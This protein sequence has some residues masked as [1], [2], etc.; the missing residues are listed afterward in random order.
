MFDINYYN[1]KFK[2]NLGSIGGSTPSEG[3]SNWELWGSAKGTN[4]ITLPTEYS[5]VMFIVR[6][7]SGSDMTTR[8]IHYSLEELT[9]MKDDTLKQKPTN[10]ERNIYTEDITSGLSD[11]NYILTYYFNDN[12][13]AIKTHKGQTPS[14]IY[15]LSVYYKKKSPI[16]VNVGTESNWALWGETTGT[17]AI[18]LPSDYSEIYITMTDT[19]YHTTHFSGTYIKSDIE[20][21]LELSGATETYLFTTNGAT[22]GYT[23]VAYTGTSIKPH[24]YNSVTPSSNIKTTVYYKKKCDNVLDINDMGEWKLQGSATGTNKITLPNEYKEILLFTVN[25]QIQYNTH[26]FK[27]HIDKLNTAYSEHKFYGTSANNTLNTYYSY[28][29]SDNTFK[30]SSNGTT[31]LYYR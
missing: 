11:V 5:E 3:V 13:I 26:I 31:Y 8:R 2:E 25:D 6:N 18:T 27:E 29:P 28:T 17:N 22:T 14:D 16:T 19:T 7:T 21:Q 23:G 4:K 1:E 30:F 12:S 10:T 20:K 15:Q 9:I 24:Y